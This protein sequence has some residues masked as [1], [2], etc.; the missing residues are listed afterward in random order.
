[1]WLWQLSWESATAPAFAL[2]RHPHRSWVRLPL[3]AC[4][5]FQAFVSVVLQLH[6]HL[7]FCQT[8]LHLKLNQ[9]KVLLWITKIV[10]LQREN[11]YQYYFTGVLIWIFITHFQLLAAY[12]RFCLMYVLVRRLTNLLVPS[13]DKTFVKFWIH[14]SFLNATWHDV[15]L[16]EK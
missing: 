15:F 6:S 10:V 7:S 8:A 9:A 3:K 5:F 11:N 13:L 14:F 4:K 12:S 1:M 16:T 2:H